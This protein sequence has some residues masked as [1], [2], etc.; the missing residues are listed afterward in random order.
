MSIRNVKRRLRVT[1]RR[2]RPIA[3]FP[4]SHSPDGWWS[5]NSNRTCHVLRKPDILTC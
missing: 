2:F 5:F 4:L 3:G 1:L